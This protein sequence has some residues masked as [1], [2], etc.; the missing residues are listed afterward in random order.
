MKRRKSQSSPCRLC[1]GSGLLQWES[2][3]DAVGSGGVGSYLPLPGLLP[4]RGNVQLA[5]FLQPSSRWLW[6]QPALTCFLTANTNSAW[7]AYCH[8]HSPYGLLRFL[9]CLA[10]SGYSS[11]AWFTAPWGVRQAL[12]GGQA[13]NPKH[14]PSL[15]LERSDNWQCGAWE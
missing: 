13:A 8:F 10:E 12:A 3:T 11:A 14:S 6:C 2:A 1:F 4:L 7:C 5:F 15:R 9:R